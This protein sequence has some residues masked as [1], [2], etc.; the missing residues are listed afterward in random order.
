MAY[1]VDLTPAARRELRKLDPGIQRRLVR[2]ILE[3]ERDPRPSGTKALSGSTGMR[4]RVRMYRLLYEV[5]D[6]RKRVV[7]FRVGHRREIYRNL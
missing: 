2:A 7:I 4:L 1:A 3:L 5:D 6:L